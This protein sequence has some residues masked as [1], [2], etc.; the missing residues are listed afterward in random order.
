MKPR[1]CVN[2][3]LSGNLSATDFLKKAAYFYGT[4]LKLIS[5]PNYIRLLQIS[6]LSYLEIKSYYG[7]KALFF[8]LYKD[9]DGVIK[10]DV[11][12]ELEES[13]NNSMVKAENTLLDYDSF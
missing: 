3:A 1:D 8:T 4:N 9:S 11:S 10:S 2:W 6:L 7:K 13:K 12:T 5:I